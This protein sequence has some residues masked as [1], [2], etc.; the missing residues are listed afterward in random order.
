MSRLFPARRK[1]GVLRIAVSGSVVHRLLVPLVQRHRRLAVLLIAIQIVATAACSGAEQQAAVTPV[2]ASR[3]D[4]GTYAPVDKPTVLTYYYY[5]YDAPTNLHLGPNQPLPTHPPPVPQPSWHSLAWHKAQLADMAAAGIDIVLPVYWGYGREQWS[6]GGLRYIDQ[7]REQLVAEGKPA[8]GI[9]MFFDTTPMAGL[10]LTSEA[11]M[12]SFFSN[13][14]DFFA[15][16]PRTDWGLID[17][18]PVVWLYIPQ[19]GNVFNQSLFDYI[20]QQFLGEFSVRPFIVREAGWYCA[21]TAWANAGPSRRDCSRPIRT[22]GM[23]HWGGAYDG[24]KDVGNVAEVGPGYDERQIPG[25]R[26]L[27]RPRDGGRWYTTNL[28]LGLE[29]K[30]RLLALET[31]NEYHE[32]TAIGDTVEYGLTYINL[33]SQYTARFHASL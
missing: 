30:K 18:R 25:R 14:K 16:V 15:R 31:W 6:T 22:D 19:N 23:Y 1:P 7:A 12:T 28:E 26:G 9:G 11:G 3:S 27:V 32:A 17:K 8:P 5:W 10:D 24:Y 33:T 2:P 20:Y 13:I 29:S 4:A 21:I